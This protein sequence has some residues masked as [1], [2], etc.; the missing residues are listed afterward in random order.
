[1]NDK[2]ISHRV[3]CT[4]TENLRDRFPGGFFAYTTR[5]RVRLHPWF[6]Y[7]KNFC[8]YID[9]GLYLVEK[10]GAGLIYET[11]MEAELAEIR[12]LPLPADIRVM[13]EAPVSFN[14]HVL[15]DGKLILVKNESF[16]IDFVVLIKLIV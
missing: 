11:A 6:L 1:M 12:A 13:N 10:H 3:N 5:G 2:C 7:P 16:H 14:Y 8:R 4:R 15:K 9:L